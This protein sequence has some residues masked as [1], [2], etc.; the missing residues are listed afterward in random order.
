MVIEKGKYTK[1][2]FGPM[3]KRAHKLWQED[4]GIKPM[5]LWRKLIAEGFEL[6]NRVVYAWTA[7]WRGGPVYGKKE[8]V[9][10]VDRAIEQVKAKS[11]MPKFEVI[12]EA[13]VIAFELAAK[14]PIL[15]EANNRLRNQL[16]AKRNEVEVVRRKYQGDLDQKRRFKLAVEQGEIGKDVENP[17]DLILTKNESH[18]S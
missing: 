3:R 18:V 4:P 8:P 11:V 2:A 10:K 17:N 12:K 6:Q 9:E 15:E 1:R 5:H 13:I 7:K 16:A 14:V